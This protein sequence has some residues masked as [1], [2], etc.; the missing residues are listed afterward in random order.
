MVALFLNL[1]MFPFIVLQSKNGFVDLLSIKDSIGAFQDDKGTKIRKTKQNIIL[2]KI[3]SIENK[4]I[5]SPL[6]EG[7]SDYICVIPGFPTRAPTFVNVE[8][9]HIMFDGN[10]YDM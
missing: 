7:Y 10:I 9:K 4:T 8:S 1:S 3:W 6:F 2:K 5:K